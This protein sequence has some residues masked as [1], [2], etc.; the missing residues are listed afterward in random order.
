[1]INVNNFKYRDIVRLNNLFPN[2]LRQ[3][4]PE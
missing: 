3:L 1:M 2:D 4:I